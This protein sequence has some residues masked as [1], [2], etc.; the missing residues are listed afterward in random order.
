[1][2][3]LIAKGRSPQIAIPLMAAFF[4]EAMRF[5]KD[6]PDALV[7]F[8]VATAVSLY[9]KVFHSHTWAQT[10]VKWFL[11]F[12]LGTLLG[13]EAF[14]LFGGLTLES[15]ASLV[16]MFGFSIYDGL[17]KMIE[18]TDLSIYLN[19][20]LSAIAE[21]AKSWIPSFKKSVAP[22]KEE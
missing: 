15:W 2:K 20:I 6:R 11:S 16:T 1:M 17:I 9:G 4:F 10:G 19:V 7:A 14:L 12:V 22:K 5:C 13:K 21:N 8:L 18:K 3:R